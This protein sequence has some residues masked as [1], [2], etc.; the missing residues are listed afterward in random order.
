MLCFY[1]SYVLSSFLAMFYCHCIDVH[2]SHVNED[3]LVNTYLPTSSN[4]DIVCV[5]AF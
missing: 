2:L 3:Y 1:C 5:V 4:M